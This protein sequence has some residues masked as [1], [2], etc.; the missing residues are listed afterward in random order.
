[1]LD[2]AAA[3]PETFTPCRGTGFVLRLA[4]AAP[5]AAATG[6]AA[7]AP[8]AAA[9]VTLELVEV[10]AAAPRPGQPRPSFSLVFRGPRGLYLPQ[11]VYRLEHEDL[12]LLDLFLVPIQPNAEGSL[13]EAVFN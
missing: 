7:A 11:R 13:F 1:M 4:P 8:P 9:P 2:L 3:T 6:A 12:G 10:N 5:P